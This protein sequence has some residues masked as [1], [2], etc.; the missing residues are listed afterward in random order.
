M[1]HAA[2][3]ASVQRN[4]GGPQGIS[5]TAARIT[6]LRTTIKSGETIR[7]ADI[8]ELTELVNIFLGH[9]HSYYDLA[10][11]AT[12]GTQDNRGNH[13]R[14]TY[15]STKNTSAGSGFPGAVA[16]ISQGVT[17]FASYHNQLADRSRQ[18]K[19]HLHP[20]TDEYNRTISV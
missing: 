15:E 1:A 16:S 10:Q 12:F 2:T 11:I 13:D 6:A 3:A 4:T 17:I 14:A 18:L 19:S 9:Y 8:N 20:F 7:A 5:G